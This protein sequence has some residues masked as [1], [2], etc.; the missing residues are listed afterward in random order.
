MKPAHIQELSRYTNWLEKAKHDI[1]LYKQTFNVFDLANVFLSLNALPEW[2]AK[3]DDAPSGLRALACKK[4]H[5]M[6]GANDTFYLDET[7]LS[8]L[9]HQLRFIRV[10]CNHSKHADK[11]KELPQI[12][13]STTFPLTFP[14]KFDRI[15]IGS[16][17]IE[18]LPILESVIR[19]WEQEITSA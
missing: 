15:H 16:I 8:D 2:I 17:T 5:I 14:V 12:T 6:K 13:M 10:F 3:S 9:D 19:Y 11:K 4:L 1:L 7:K 18:A